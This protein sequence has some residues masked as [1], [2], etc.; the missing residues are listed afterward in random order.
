MDYKNFETIKK[1]IIKAL[2]S[3]DELMDRLVLKG[4]SALDLVYAYPSGRASIDI[5][6]SME[7]DF[8]PSALPEI[9]TKIEKLLQ[10]AFNEKGYQ[11]IDFGLK[12]RPSKK[13]AGIPDFWGGY[14]I[15]FKLVSRQSY[16]RFQTDPRQLRMQSEIL[17]WKMKR[18]FR[19]EISKHEYCGEKKDYELDGYAIR[20]YSPAMIVAEKLRAICQQLPAYPYTG[21]SKR[22]RARDFYD[23][24]LVQEHEPEIKW[25]GKEFRD[26][27]QKVFAAKGVELKLLSA[28]ER[29][30][31][32]AFHSTDFPAVKATVDLKAG[33]HLQKFD[34]YFDYVTG[35]I[36]RL[37]AFW[38]K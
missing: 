7:T 26:L 37:K 4:G 27:L 8:S 29:P 2:F 35:F 25:S 24:Y 33:H 31:V 9:T 32:R 3:D 5:D 34:F 19:I 16:F 15:G 18:N 17:G 12:P 1:N 10:N 22:P 11:V 20:V 14:E 21:R 23:I 36:A 38:E 13:R 28:V 6:L 30:E